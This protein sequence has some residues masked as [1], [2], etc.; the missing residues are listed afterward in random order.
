MRSSKVNFLQDR[1]SSGSGFYQSKKT[2]V[3]A[4]N[5]HCVPTYRFSPSLGRVLKKT[6]NIS[7]YSNMIMIVTTVLRDQVSEKKLLFWMI[8]KYPFFSTP[9]IYRFFP[10]LGKCIIPPELFVLKATHLSVWWIFHQYI[11]LC[12][13][14]R[15]GALK[16]M[17]A[18]IVYCLTFL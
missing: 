5:L 17:T 11:F 10:S 7:G 2:E 13:A 18:A 12:V 14:R 15:S 1:F 8:Q 6:T 4:I 9:F 3:A 16:E